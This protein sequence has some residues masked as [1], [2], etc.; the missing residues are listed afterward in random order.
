MKHI[1][2]C[3]S[4]LSVSLSMILITQPFDTAFATNKAE[5][6]CQTEEALRAKILEPDNF[7][8]IEGG[9]GK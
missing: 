3:F 1:F 9:I 6:L 7:K 5:I 8:G 4:I 2:S